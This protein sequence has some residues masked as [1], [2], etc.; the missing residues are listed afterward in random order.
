MHE[1]LIFGFFEFFSPFWHLD[2]FSMTDP[3]ITTPHRPPKKTDFDNFFYQKIEKEYF[4][5]SGISMIAF[6][7]NY[8]ERFY[9]L[10]DFQ[11]KFIEGFPI[12]FEYQ[13][14]LKI[15]LVQRA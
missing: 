4:H 5:S 2:R 12:V 14:Y 15:D 8:L 3:H 10:G 7:E 11:Y 9:D 6:L 1:F 13:K